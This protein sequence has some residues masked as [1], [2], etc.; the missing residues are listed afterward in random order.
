VDAE[1]VL[2]WSFCTFVPGGSFWDFGSGRL[3][4]K[5]GDGSRLS[6]VGQTFKTLTAPQ[7]PVS[8][9]ATEAIR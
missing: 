3:Q 5:W 7:S 2:V 8:V 9:P 6:L 1:A 4:Q